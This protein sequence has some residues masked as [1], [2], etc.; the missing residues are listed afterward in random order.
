MSQVS[1]SCFRRHIE[2]HFDDHD[3]DVVCRKR[4]NNYCIYWADDRTPL[5][6]L[7]PAGC[8]DDVEVSWWNGDCWDRVTDFGLV[9]PVAQ[10]LQYIT[11]DP[12]DLFFDGDDDP[13]ENGLPCEFTDPRAA[14]LIRTMHGLL[15]VC[16]LLGAVVGGACSD[17][18]TALL[19]GSV[20]ITALAG[21][22]LVRVCPRR[23]LI[24]SLA[25]LIL[26]AMVLAS[27]AAI[28]GNG[29]NQALGGGVW[30]IGLGAIVGAACILLL[31]AGGLSARFVG[32]WAGLLAAAWLVAAFALQ[33]HFGGLLLTATL[34]SIASASYGWFMTGYRKAI[35]QVL[36]ITGEDG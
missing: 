27:P 33:G 14:V 31:A 26:G 4:K 25:V 3:L 22:L 34:A 6:R 24:A 20:A 5:A 7:K 10:A 30:G 15:H 36:A 11:D 32:F 2:D 13:E 21:L 29:V 9:L 35:K 1:T 8:N 18:K 28:V 12:D 23:E 16:G 17:L 19:W